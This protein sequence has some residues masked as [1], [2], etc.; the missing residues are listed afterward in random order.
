MPAAGDKRKVDW[1]RWRLLCQIE[2]AIE[3]PMAFLGLAW[4]ALLV[5]EFTRGL[6]PA[7]AAAVDVIWALFILDF[8]VRLLVAPRKLG[9]LRRNVLTAVSLMLP[10]LR[11]LRVLRLLRLVRG[12]R[13][14]KVLASLN[15]GMRSLRRALG[16]TGFGYVAGLTV[17]VVLVGAAGMHALEA[18]ESF[19]T[20]GDALWWTAMLVTSIGSEAWPRTPEGRVLCVILAIYGFALFGYVT[21]TLARVFIGE[22][23]R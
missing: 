16:R 4:A 10:A 11:M 17:L 15:R 18:G 20:Y 9:F 13:L 7:L 21:A 3:L 2:R 23:G 12:L 5:V 19:D 8:L 1:E 14:V 22:R 6:T